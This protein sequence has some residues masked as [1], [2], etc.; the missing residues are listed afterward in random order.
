[1]TATRWGC[2]TLGR[3]REIISYGAWRGETSL[4]PTGS[5]PPEHSWL[6]H[7]VN[8]LASYI[9]GTYVVGPIR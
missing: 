9:S 4:N 3:Y 6:L 5:L 2:T 1:M 8:N 7:M